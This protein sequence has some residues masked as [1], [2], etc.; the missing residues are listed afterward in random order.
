[1]PHK[2][3]MDLVLK[4]AIEQYVSSYCMLQ[5]R[6]KFPQHANSEAYH[7]ECDAYF[8]TMFEEIMDTMTVTLKLPGWTSTSLPLDEQTFLKLE[9][10]YGK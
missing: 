3:Q 8:E 5:T 2:F 4:G 9:A 6:K 1:M 7:E 10:T